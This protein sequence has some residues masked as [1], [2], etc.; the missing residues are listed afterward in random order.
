MLCSSLLLLFLFLL[1]P[2]RSV[3]L[4]N[5]A[6]I[7][8]KLTLNSPS[9]PCSNRNFR[10]FS[11]NFRRKFMYCSQS[12]VQQQS[13]RGTGA[14]RHGCRRRHG[15]QRGHSGHGR[16]ERDAVAAEQVRRLRNHPRGRHHGHHGWHGDVRDTGGTGDSHWH[17]QLAS[18]RH[19]EESCA[20]LCG[21]ERQRGHRRDVRHRHEPLWEGCCRRD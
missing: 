2:L 21:G 3:V 8:K 18:A 1:A 14:R 19:R 11:P 5:N 6:R 16:R 9:K 13:L 10:E 4:R 20:R 12:S 15:R 7:E 17:L